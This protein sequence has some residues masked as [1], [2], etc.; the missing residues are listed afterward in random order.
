MAWI[1]TLMTGLSLLLAPAALA[2]ETTVLLR[3]ISPS[4]SGSGTAIG[5]VLLRDTPRGLRII[6]RLQSLP[7]GEHGLH[8]HENPDCGPGEK[9]GAVVAGLAA[10]GHFDPG[11]TGVHAGPLGEG[12]LGDLP[13][14]TVDEDGSSAE[15]LL[16]PR[17]QLEQ[18][19]GRAMIVHAGGDNYRDQ[20]EPLGGGGARIACGLI[21]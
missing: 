19:R 7:P 16:A 3:T 18:I 4:G 5:N 6:T 11:G 12:H 17:L 15:T 10:G 13:R 14:I 2:G 8:V 9:D 21:P 20:P 1:L